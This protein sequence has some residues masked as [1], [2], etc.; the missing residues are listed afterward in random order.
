MVVVGVDG[1]SLAVRPGE[2][3]N[4]LS[5]GGGLNFLRTYKPVTP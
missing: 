5:P 1:L 3:V 2:G 4:Q